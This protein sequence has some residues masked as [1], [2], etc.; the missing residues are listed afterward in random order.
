MRRQLYGLPRIGTE[1]GIHQTLG[2]ALPIRSGIFVPD[3]AVVPRAAVR[4]PGR[5]VAAGE[6]A[7]VVEVT[8][9]GNAGQDRVTKAAA[10]AQEG[11]PLCLLVD[12]RAT[13]TPGLVLYG[14]PGAGVYRTP[15]SGEFGDA[16]P[17]PSPPPSGA[18]STPPNSP[19]PESGA[20][21][22]RKPRESPSQFSA[23]SH[24]GGA[25]SGA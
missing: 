7:L 6:A 12:C 2:P 10:H 17:L 9:K 14:E 22:R 5:Y 4:G 19:F 13:D 18:R 23:A 3:L 15:W 21:P 25:R 20:G 16:V 11:V 1:F 24:L 8:S